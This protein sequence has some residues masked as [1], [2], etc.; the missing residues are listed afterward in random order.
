MR[1]NSYSRNFTYVGIGAGLVLF[2]LFGFYPGSLL[3]GAAGVKM[4]GLLLG[5]PLDPGLVSRAIVLLSM[6]VGIAASGVMTVTATSSLGWIIGKAV[7]AAVQ[8][9][10]VKA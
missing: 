3:G 10:T 4:T 6:L 8:E 9:R 7:D 1:I 5:L 2:G